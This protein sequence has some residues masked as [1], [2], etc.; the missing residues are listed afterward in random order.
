MVAGTG[1]FD[2]PSE[3]FFNLSPEKRNEI[4]QV[5]LEEFAEQGYDGASTNRMVERAG[6]SKGVLFK[7]FKDKESLFHYVCHETIQFWLDELRIPATE[8]H[9]DLFALLK[10]VAIRKIAM[11]KRYPAA[12][13]LFLRITQNADH[14]VYA[15]VAHTFPDITHQY[16]ENLTTLL[17]QDKLRPGVDWTQ[18]ITAVMW[19]SE[20]I[21]N[22]Y[23]GTAPQAAD[24]EQFDAFCEQILQEMDQY[25]AIL[26]HG[27]YREEQ[28]A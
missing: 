3:Q 13:R 24:G 10:S 19:I 4:I 5:C 17:P 15:K 21:Q 26:K 23:L 14:P 8:S 7:Y 6:I 22:R 16:M 1:G 25:F 2:M 27:I 11:S 9:S 20:G 28:E 12:Y 18:A